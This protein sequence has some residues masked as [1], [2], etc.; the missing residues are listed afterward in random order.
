MHS[1]Q[2]LQ[3]ILSHVIVIHCGKKNFKYLLRPKNVYDNKNIY[4]LGGYK[5][6]PVLVVF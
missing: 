3:V 4:L 2:K 5:V 1:I 6:L